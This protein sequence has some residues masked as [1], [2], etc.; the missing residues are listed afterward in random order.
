MDYA[1]GPVDPAALA[2]ADQADAATS[3]LLR[4]NGLELVEGWPFEP[5]LI[6]GLSAAG[7]LEA[8]SVSAM[9][10]EEARCS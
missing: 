8:L 4:D 5:E 6:D 9:K 7:L 2:G 3:D 1:D 10:A